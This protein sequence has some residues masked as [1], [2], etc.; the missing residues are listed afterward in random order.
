MGSGRLTWRTL[1]REDFSSVKEEQVQASDRRSPLREKTFARRRD[2]NQALRLCED[3]LVE[4]GACDESCVSWD[5]V[6]R[7]RCSLRIGW[8]VFTHGLFRGLLPPCSFM[9]TSA[10]WRALFPRAVRVLTVLPFDCLL[11]ARAP[12]EKE[13]RVVTTARGWTCEEQFVNVVQFWLR[14]TK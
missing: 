2:I 12:Q 7:V 5:R 8:S 14:A 11:V 3:R 9:L 13:E 4:V 10:M 6:S 1:L